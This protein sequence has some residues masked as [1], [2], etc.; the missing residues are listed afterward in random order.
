MNGAQDLQTGRSTWAA[1]L[2][3]LQWTF[4]YTRCANLLPRTPSLEASRPLRVSHEPGQPHG[5]TL[6][7]ASARAPRRGARRSQPLLHL[8][9]VSLIIPPSEFTLLTSSAASSS[10]PPAPGGTPSSGGA[11]AA[12]AAGAANPNSTLRLGQDGTITGSGAPGTFWVRAL[13]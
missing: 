1:N 6:T 3:L 11:A 12:A 2:T 9:N 7:R 8:R 5:R 4:N 13:P 10:S